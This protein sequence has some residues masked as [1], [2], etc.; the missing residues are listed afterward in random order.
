MI[1]AIL[2]F[3]TFA[4]FLTGYLGMSRNSRL[5]IVFAMFLSILLSLLVLAETNSFS[6]RMGGWAPWATISFLVG[7]VFL[8]QLFIKILK[9]NPK[10]INQMIMK[11]MTNFLSMNL[12]VI[13]DTLY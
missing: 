1:V 11:K 3:I 2:S 4:W 7:L 12:S 10:T 13:Q 9:T 6:I 5:G 8:F